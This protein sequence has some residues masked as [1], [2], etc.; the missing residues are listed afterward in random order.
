MVSPSTPY[1][2]CIVCMK[3]QNGKKAKV[4][5]YVNSIYANMGG[6]D[7]LHSNKPCDFRLI[8][9]VFE[10]YN[11]EVGSM[12]ICDDIFVLIWSQIRIV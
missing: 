3:Q 12:A 1:K 2:D 10:M 11:L 4:S 8:L 6:P 7:D 9:Y 5:F